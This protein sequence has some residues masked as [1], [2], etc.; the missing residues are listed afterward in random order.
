MESAKSAKDATDVVPEE[1]KFADGFI[2]SKRNT[3][4]RIKQELLSQIQ[5]IE[6]QKTVII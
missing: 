6:E 3:Q 4:L 2:R 1:E 5:T